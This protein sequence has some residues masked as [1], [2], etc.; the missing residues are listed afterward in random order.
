MKGLDLHN[1]MTEIDESFI[2]EAD[3]ILTNSR[4]C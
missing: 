1:A 2:K 4:V 3:Q